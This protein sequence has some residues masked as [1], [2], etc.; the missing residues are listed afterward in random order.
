M[1]LNVTPIVAKNAMTQ[2]VQPYVSIPNKTAKL[3][4]NE[5]L[6]S[7]PESLH[8]RGGKIH[9]HR[10]DRGHKDIKKNVQNNEPDPEVFLHR[11]IAAIQ[12]I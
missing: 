2:L 8:E 1:T 4:K 6:P 3:E 11:F 10:A 7:F 9:H 5:P 12:R